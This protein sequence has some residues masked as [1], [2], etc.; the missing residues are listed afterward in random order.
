MPRGKP[1]TSASGRIEQS[2][3]RNQKRAG[4]R[5]AA[6]LLPRRAATKPCV[7]IVGIGRSV[8]L[9]LVSTDFSHTKPQSC[10]TPRLA[11]ADIRIKL[12]CHRRGKSQTIL[13]ALAATGILGMSV[14]TEWSGAYAV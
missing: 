1:S 8:Q 11:R 13:V 12:R 10:G 14:E 9:A 6:R 3:D 2:T 7:T 4:I 5:P